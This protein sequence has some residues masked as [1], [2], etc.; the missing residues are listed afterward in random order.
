MLNENENIGRIILKSAPVLILLT[1]V[2]YFANVS[3]N[4]RPEW[5]SAY[6]MIL[7][8]SILS[9][10][11]FT[12]M[13]YPC[14]KIPF[15]F[16]LLIS[17]VMYLTNGSMFW[18]NAYMLIFVA[19][20]F[21]MIYKNFSTVHPRP[22]ALLIA[23]L[24][25]WSTLMLFYAGYVMIEF[26]YLAFSFLSLFFIFTYTEKAPSLLNGILAVLFLLISFFLRTV[27]VA[28]IAG[29]LVYLLVHRFR[30]IKTVNFAALAFLL[31]IPITTWMVKNHYTQ[32]NLNDPV[33]QLQEFIPSK[34]EVKRYRFDD[35]TS[36]V[37]GLQDLVRRG[38][39]NTGYYG[40]I[41]S[42]LLLGSNFR[43]KREFFSD[44]RSLPIFILLG[45][46]ILL[47]VIGFLSSIRKR[48]T[49][50]DYYF[51]LYMGILLAWS[52]REP[53]Y[54]LPVLPM[55]IHY[56]LNGLAFLSS[57]AAVLMKTEKWRTQIAAIS[58]AGFTLFYFA[59]NSVRHVQTIKEQHKRDYYPY[60]M[61]NFLQVIE[62][63]RENT[64]EE[65]RI[66][67]VLAPV[68]AYF[69]ERW[70][71]S[72]PRVEDESQIVFFL[73][74]IKGDYLLTN[75]SY[76]KEEKYLEAVLK[77]Y[78]FLFHKEHAIGDAA[79]YRIDQERLS[80]FFSQEVIPVTG[81]I[82]SAETVY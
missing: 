70:T 77:N 64:E 61:S 45:F 59:S 39:H 43:L 8:K 74:Q 48:R 79:V 1:A 34:N 3:I 28:L 33:W 56:F 35:P 54:I 24:S 47:I 58:I 5:D 29:T 51:V 14:L 57:T 63:L 68:T 72:F 80:I 18:L 17:P 26:P 4:W 11:G 22:Y 21:L 27:G 49:L 62:W 9:G 13:N 16:P 7:A 32:I 36:S 2:L 78:S 73:L 82:P 75:P 40:A 55:I 30:L 12:Y 52:A 25:A 19:T 67:S 15:G 60:H 65:A 42:S 41:S 31:T 66:I 44:I 53:R 38:I 69:S 46:C 76:G 6:Y 50:L 37:N 71:V 23:F 10:N 81:S 20:S